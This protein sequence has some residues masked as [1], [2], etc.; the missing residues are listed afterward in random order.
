MSKGKEM[1]PLRKERIEGKLQKMEGMPQ[2]LA[3]TA[4]EVLQNQGNEELLEKTARQLERQI[5]E[6]KCKIE[7]RQYLTD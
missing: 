2:I 6:T 1:T 4:K 5:N 3:A 7:I